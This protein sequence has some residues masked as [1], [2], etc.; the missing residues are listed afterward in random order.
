MIVELVGLPGVG[1][2]TLAEAFREMY[3]APVISPRGKLEILFGALGSCVFYPG[4]SLGLLK[5]FFRYSRAGTRYYLFVNS[6]LYKLAKFYYGKRSH[7]CLIAEGLVHNLLSLWGREVS[8][9]EAFDDLGRLPL[10]DMVVLVEHDTSTVAASN[11]YRARVDLGEKDIETWQRTLRAN[12][13]TL[14]EALKARSV[15]TR[16]VTRESGLRELQNIF[17]KNS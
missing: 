7:T 4:L 1:K 16:Y 5:M 8:L 15:P 9:Q 11:A 3:L 12:L 13:K 2:T 14:E 17:T 10:P 6:V